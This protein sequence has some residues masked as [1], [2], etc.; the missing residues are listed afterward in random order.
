MTTMNDDSLA[1]YHQAMYSSQSREQGQSARF[2][3]PTFQIPPF[4]YMGPPTLAPGGGA[5][6]LP[7]GGSMWMENSGFNF[8]AFER[9]V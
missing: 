7:P 4:M 1:E 9:S 5:E 8:N 3:Q 2:S 6:V